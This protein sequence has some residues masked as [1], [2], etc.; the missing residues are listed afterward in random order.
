MKK[1]IKRQLILGIALFA[2]FILYTVSLTLVDIQ[3]I[4][5]QRPYAAY[6]GINKAVHEWFGVNMLLCNITDWAGL[7]AIAS[8]LQFAIPGLVP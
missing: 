4:G 1:R 6:A 7:A 2:M 8:A 5:P 3:P